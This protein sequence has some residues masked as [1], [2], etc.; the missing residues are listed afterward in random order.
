M[1]AQGL[2]VLRT[3]DPWVLISIFRLGR[4]YDFIDTTSF[5]NFYSRFRK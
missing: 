2:A 3:I 4:E 5:N 1:I